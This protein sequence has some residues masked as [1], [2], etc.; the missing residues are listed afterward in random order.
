[1]FDNYGIKDVFYGL[2]KYK[3]YIAIILVVFTL[4]GYCLGVSGLAN[5]KEGDYC[6]SVTYFVTT[7]ENK[8]DTKM[9]N[10]S[11]EYA[12][13]LR[14]MLSADFC[15]EVVFNSLCEKYTAT[16]LS[17]ILN[18]SEQKLNFISIQEVSTVSVLSGTS[19]VN[20][21]VESEDEQFAQDLLNA[22]KS[23]VETDKVLKTFCSIREVGGANQQLKG[24]SAASPVKIA[25]IFFIV[26]AFLSAVFVFVITLT[27]PTL[28]ERADI[29]QYGVTGLG[30]LN[31]KL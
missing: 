20:L 29:E 26:G 19:M 8:S 25:M 14:A 13:N 30:E 2:W 15:Y 3:F 17:E 1:M 27:R 24:E 10:D 12:E 23:Y 18:V 21:Y 6:A 11:K 28:N 31:S 9:Y 7:K 4:L 22:Y 16:E 5:V